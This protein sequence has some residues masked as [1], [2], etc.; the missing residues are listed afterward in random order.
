MKVTGQLS[1]S[2][3]ISRSDLA[4][5]FGQNLEFDKPLA[6]FTSF[7]TGGP[8]R[9]FLHAR[10][11]DQVARAVKMAQELRIPFFLLGGGS[12]V[13]VSD[14][15]F[16]G[17]IVKVDIQGLRVIEETLIEAGAGES[18]MSVVKFATE[19]SLTGLEFA[20]GIWGALG[21]A[22][23]GNAG[24][25]GGE[26]GNIVN[27]V[28]LVTQE[29]DVR[30]VSPEYC[31]FSYRDSYLK[32]THDIVVKATLRLTPGVSEE[33][34]ARVENIVAQ[35]VQKHPERL[36]AGCVFKNIPDP[37]Q[38]Y[39][40]LPA[41]RLLEQAGAKMMSVGGARVF[42]KHANIIVNSGSATSADISQLVDMM[43]AAVLEKFGIE[44]EE[45]IIRIG[46]F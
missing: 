43:K 26:I 8:A 4:Q 46:N 7:D 36:T 21:G 19:N 33:I 44:L 5:A 11:V 3:N 45:E 42:E 24:A 9:Y 25:F 38:E 27:S 28:T 22:I 39:G 40:K 23:Y 16:D 10:A 31:R 18:L 35:R 15:G 34:R 12:N 30:T 41:G 2:S 20:A 32:K 29:G 6:P 13:L 17:L 1:L 37:S 14:H